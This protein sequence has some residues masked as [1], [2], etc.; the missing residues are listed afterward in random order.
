M[1]A[2]G[3]AIYS[4]LSDEDFL[5][6]GGS[7]FT[8]FLMRPD[9]LRF[10]RMISIE[11][12]RDEALARMWN[13]HLFEEPIAFQTGLFEMLT[14]AGAMRP[15]DP[16]LLALEFYTPL[17]MLYLNALPFEPDSPEFARA[18]EF[19]NRHMTHFRKTYGINRKD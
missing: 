11:R 1:L 5:L 10:W 19:A 13:R 4:Q 9:V 16:V 8:D 2:Q 7:V 15:L 3:A 12:F 6:I 17:L 14:G 18:L